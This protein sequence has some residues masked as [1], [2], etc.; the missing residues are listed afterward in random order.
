MSK[1]ENI[2]VARETSN[3]VSRAFFCLLGLLVVSFWPQWWCV[4]VVGTCLPP[5]EQGLVAVG[6]LV[7]VREASS[8][9]VNKY[10]INFLFSQMK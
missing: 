5:H 6:G 8:S 9:V 7:R 4:I 3:D 10:L 2:P 1:K